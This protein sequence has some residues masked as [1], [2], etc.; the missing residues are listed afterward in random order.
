MRYRSC[1]RHSAEILRVTSS[2]CTAWD[3]DDS[4]QRTMNQFRY[5]VTKVSMTIGLQIRTFSILNR[6]IGL[7]FFVM[8]NRSI[9]MG[10]ADLQI[11]RSLFRQM[12]NATANWG[13]QIGNYCPQNTPR[14]CRPKTMAKQYCGR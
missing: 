8:V 11:R 13:S 14:V 1:Y 5:V 9:F 10:R 4:I 6:H 12:L 2:I 3:A 7:F